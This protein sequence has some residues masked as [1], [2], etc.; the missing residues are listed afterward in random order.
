MWG[1]I[2]VFSFSALKDC[3]RDISEPIHSIILLVSIFDL[4]HILSQ[5]VFY[6]YTYLVYSLISQYWQPR[7]SLFHKI[8][9]LNKLKYLYS[10]QNSDTSLKCLIILQLYFWL[11]LIWI[12]HF[13]ISLFKLCFLVK[14]RYL[15][16]LKQR[17]RGAAAS[18][19]HTLWTEGQELMG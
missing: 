7:N 11:F 2:G 6:G 13:H 4:I 10:Q 9:E 5:A 19:G 18:S 12:Y 3:Y 17:T 15:N 16:V 1:D 14:I 8:C